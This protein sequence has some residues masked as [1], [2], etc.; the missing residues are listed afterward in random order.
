MD[1]CVGKSNDFVGAFRHGVKAI[2]THGVS[3]MPLAYPGDFFI[4]SNM[5]CLISYD[6]F[7]VIVAM[8]KSVKSNKDSSSI[9]HIS[10]CAT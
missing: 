1:N 4:I 7:L 9:L 6:Y 5:R 10:Y 8:P 3:G 2:F